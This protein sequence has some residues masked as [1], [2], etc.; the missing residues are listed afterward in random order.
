MELHRLTQHVY[1]SDS[2][3][4]GDRPVLGLVAGREAT[5]AV[6]CGNSPAHAAWLLEMP[7]AKKYR[8]EYLSRKE[9]TL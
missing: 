2:V 7:T 8:A 1:Y 6:D 3:S 9:N 5:L 4:C